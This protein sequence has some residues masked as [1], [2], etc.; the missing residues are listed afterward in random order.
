MSHTYE[1]PPLT[2]AQIVEMRE[3]ASGNNVPWDRERLTRE[4]LA[5]HKARR[6]RAIR[7]RAGVIAFAVLCLLVIAALWWVRR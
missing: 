7:I 1:R 5:K 4:L 2:E 6:R 3:R